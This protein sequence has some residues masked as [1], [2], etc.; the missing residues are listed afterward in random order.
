[1]VL[2]CVDNDEAVVCT[3]GSH[4]ESEDPRVHKLQEGR[5]GVHH[6]QGV[7]SFPS[8]VGISMP[9]K[10]RNWILVNVPPISN[11]LFVPDEISEVSQV[12]VREFDVSLAT[13]RWSK[14]NTLEWDHERGAVCGEGLWLSEVLLSQSG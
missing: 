12:L 1:M 11:V 14:K 7:M 9:M 8:V 4:C 2:L 5:P 6:V 10:H 3:V 13:A